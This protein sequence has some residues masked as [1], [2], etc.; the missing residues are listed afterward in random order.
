MDRLDQ[1]DHLDQEESVEILDQRDHLE[2]QVHKV[3][4]DPPVH[5]LLPWRICLEALRITILV[6]LLLISQKTRLCPNQIQQT[7]SKLT[8]ESRPPLRLSAAKLTACAAL[9]VVRNTLH[10]HVRTLSSATRLKRVV[11]TG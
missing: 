9:M 1:W 8:Q 3:H 6:L 7:C 11:N 10:A 5:Q 2:S 4:P